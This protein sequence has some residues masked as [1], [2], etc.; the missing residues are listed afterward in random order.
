ML[1]FL[2]S[3]MNNHAN[4]TTTRCCNDVLW[5]ISPGIPFSC[6]CVDI[7]E[8]CE[9]TCKKC[10]CKQPKQCSCDDYNEYCIQC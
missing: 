1:L 8:T 9:S 7:A 4:S 2:L 6:Q 3:L 5:Y 10:T